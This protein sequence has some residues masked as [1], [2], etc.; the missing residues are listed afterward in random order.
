MKASTDTATLKRD[1]LVMSM[2]HDHVPLALLI[3]LTSTDGPRSTEILSAEGR[4]ET[5]WWAAG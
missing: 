5:A 3:D 4:P 2:L 1:D